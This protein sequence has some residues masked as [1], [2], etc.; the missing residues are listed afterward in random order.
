MRN[1]GI[2]HTDALIVPSII[3]MAQRAFLEQ[4]GCTLWQGYLFS[5]P[6]PIEALAQ[7]LHCGLGW[8]VSS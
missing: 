7:R 6:G 4:H 5:R 2:Q 8:Q 1:V 3:G